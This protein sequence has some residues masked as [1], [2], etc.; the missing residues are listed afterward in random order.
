MIDKNVLFTEF[1]IGKAVLYVKRNYKM[2]SATPMTLLMA[3]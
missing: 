2:W 3:H 1:F